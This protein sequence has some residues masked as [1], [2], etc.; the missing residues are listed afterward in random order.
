MIVRLETSI[1]E[2]L[3]RVVPQV[4]NTQP[5]AAM[6]GMWGKFGDLGDID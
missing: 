5:T 2:G 4:E 3:D 6:K 1:R